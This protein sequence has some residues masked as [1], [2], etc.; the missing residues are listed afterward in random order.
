MTKYLFTSESVTEGHPDKI[1][2]QISDAGARR[3]HRQGPG[4]TCGV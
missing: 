3:D 4:R 2:D 1:C